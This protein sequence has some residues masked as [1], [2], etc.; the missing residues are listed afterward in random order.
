MEYL[1]SLDGSS[2]PLGGECT[3]DVQY[4]IHWM[5]LVYLWEIDSSWTR[6]G[7]KELD[8]ARVGLERAAR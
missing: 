6:E 8:S 5:S 2:L 7:C 3:L 4:E 1:G